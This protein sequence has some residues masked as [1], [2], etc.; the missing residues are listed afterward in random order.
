MQVLRLLLVNLQLPDHLNGEIFGD[1][2]DAA[3]LKQVKKK[4]Q[5]VVRQSFNGCLLFC[6]F[7]GTC[8]CFVFVCLFGLFVCTNLR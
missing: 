7:V 1:V 8:F 6:L 4:F 2:G 3:D 5:M